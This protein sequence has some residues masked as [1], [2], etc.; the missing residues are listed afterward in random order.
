MEEVDSGS[1]CIVWHKKENHV[2]VLMGIET[3]YLSDYVEYV[4]FMNMIMSNVYGNP[5][6]NLPKKVEEFEKKYK[7]NLYVPL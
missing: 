6:K 7:F 4:D 5:P 3:Q 2:C 1:A